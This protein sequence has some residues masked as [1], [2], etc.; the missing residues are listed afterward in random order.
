MWWKQVWQY[1][2]EYWFAFL[3]LLVCLS[4]A[5]PM[6]QELNFKYRQRVFTRLCQAMLV[7]LFTAALYLIFVLA[8]MFL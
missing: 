4:L 2:S 3:G 1:I 5:V 8:T 6:V 7:L